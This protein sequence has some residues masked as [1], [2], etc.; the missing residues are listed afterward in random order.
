[1][2]L[3]LHFG[4][5]PGAPAPL[6]HYPPPL[7][8]LWQE[9]LAQGSAHHAPEYSPLASSTPPSPAAPGWDQGR[10]PPPPPGTSGQA[11]P[12]CGLGGGGFCSH[13]SLQSPQ[14]IHTKEHSY[15]CSQ[16]GRTF[17]FHSK[18]ALHR[19]CHP[20][21]CQFPCCTFGSQAGLILHECS[22][23]GSQQC[24]CDDCGKTMVG[25]AEASQQQAGHADKV[26]GCSCC[27][28]GF[29]CLSDPLTHWCTRLGKLHPC[30]QCQKCFGSCADL[31]THS[32]NSGD[33]SWTGQWCVLGHLAAA[34]S[35]AHGMQGASSASAKV[36]LSSSKACS[37]KLRMCLAC[38][39]D[40]EKTL[41]K[42]E[43]EP[44]GTLLGWG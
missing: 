29:G 30:G 33:V 8:P 15:H 3:H 27:G 38:H 19:L 34:R 42:H 6:S 28:K 43:H 16:Y 14:C 9:L 2:P 35:S 13:P 7:H 12:L 11:I 39:V 24:L 31:L 22:H 18:L 20:E 37:S 40:G 36:P 26:H 5:S 10:P 17:C 32:L 23:P 21:E 41:Q 25:P 1:M 44:G 4:C